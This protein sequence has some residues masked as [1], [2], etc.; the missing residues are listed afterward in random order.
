MTAID[1]FK[2]KIKAGNVYEALTI[3]M[4]EAIE[5][6]I[7]TRI[8]SGDASDDD[9]N[10]YLRT[11]INLVDGK[12]ENE[13]GSELIGNESYDEIL[14]FHLDQVKEGQQILINNLDS[15]QKMFVILTNTLS[16]LPPSK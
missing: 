4:S 11:R 7:T 6:K 15:L 8:T 10:S 16:Q 1:Q 5:L 14:N 2:E 13:V 12:I 9:S 3:A